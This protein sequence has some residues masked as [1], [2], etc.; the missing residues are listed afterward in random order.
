MDV[1]RVACEDGRWMELDIVHSWAFVL[2]VVSILSH[3]PN[4]GEVM[5]NAKGFEARIWKGFVAEG[6]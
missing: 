1:E 2:E 3:L 5:P 6:K 4:G